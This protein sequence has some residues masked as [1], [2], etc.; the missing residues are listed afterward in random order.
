MREL[1]TTL[2]ALLLMVALA[3]C[4]D[5]EPPEDRIEI[6]MGSTPDWVIEVAGVADAIEAQP[7]ATDSIL[8]AHDMTRAELD[9]LLYVIAEDTVLI[10]TYRD[11]RD[12]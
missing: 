10:A 4:G 9:S 12:R 1:R 6:Q 5:E 8:V 3:A 2:M 7:E 11:A